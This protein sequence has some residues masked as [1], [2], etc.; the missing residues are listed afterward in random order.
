MAIFDPQLDYTNLIQFTNG[1]LKLASFVQIRNALIKRMQDIY[2]NDIDVSP[3]SADGQYINS[4][5]LLINNIFQTLRQ[6]YQS[7]D[8]ASATGQYLDTLCSFN[9]VER[10]TPSHSTAQL[11]IYNLTNNP[12]TANKLSF[13]DRNNTLW[14][15]DNGGVDKTF[16]AGTGSNPEIITDVECDEIGAVSAPGTSA[17]YKLEDGEWIEVDTPAEQSWDEIELY[18]TAKENGT[19]YQCV[20]NNGLKV[21]QYKDA[22][23]GNDEESDESLRSRRYQMLGNNSITVLEGLRGTLLNLTGI[24][25][26]YIYNNQN[27]SNVRLNYEPIN[28]ENLIYPHSIYV[29]IRY[30][31]GVEIGEEIIGKIIYNKLTPGIG[32]N[33]WNIDE[34]NTSAPLPDPNG[35]YLSYDIV[36]T[37]GLVDT[38]YWKKCD[39]QS[40]EIELNFKINPDLYD[41]P[42]DANNDPI[43]A[44]HDPDSE[45]EK[46]IVKKL[47][48][49]I[50]NVKINEYMT[51]SLL[52]AYLQQADV[53]V[54]GV[55]T[56]YSLS[57]DIDGEQIY[58]AK[59]AY[60]KYNTFKFE[61]DVAN[62]TG[63]LTISW[64]DP[65]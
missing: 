41:I 21:W 19:I 20:E 27:I 18:G 38:I 34:N 1:T 2:G 57:G 40:P 47:T 65:E 49:Y 50:D 63:T 53:L 43:E 45:V 59:L 25:D 9:N 55:N 10:I 7:L 11:Y 15:W 23:V 22:E 64:V 52:L 32:T 61:Y 14:L 3:A 30:E 62:N 26:V 39:P 60:F 31:E 33:G 29:V 17:F 24:R 37:Q 5:A 16:P 46:N 12:I 4:I 48:K 44:A 58:P 54:N 28:D 8:P 42:S 56:F 13:I 35:Q 51:V 36:R 6:G